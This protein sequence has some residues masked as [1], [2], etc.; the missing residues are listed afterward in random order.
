MSSVSREAAV[1]V[2]PRLGALPN[3]WR[4]LLAE[5]RPVPMVATLTIAYIGVA[6]GGGGFVSAATWLIL[7]AAGTGLFIAHLRDT[8]VDF[9]ERG[10]DRLLPPVG[11][12]GSNGL[13]SLR[14][15]RGLNIGASIVFWATVG[16]LLVLTE[17]VLLLPVAGAAFALAQ[18][19]G[20]GLDRH[21]LSGALTYPTGALLAFWSGYVAAGGAS[22]SLPLGL[23]AGALLAALA[24][25]KIV[26]DLIDEP[27]DPAFGK[28]TVAVAVGARSARRMGIGIVT[29]G[30]LFILVGGSLGG[31]GWIQLATMVVALSIPLGGGWQPPLRATYTVLGGI[32]VAILLLALS[33]PTL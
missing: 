13:L 2:P 30:L 7:L 23:I 16:A 9:Y 3:L 18:S 32:Y 15:L 1:S 17:A 21:P 19:Y 26:S 27:H 29:A 12:D 11:L 20:F 24:G 4:G 5:I 25:G 6:L 14:M 28:R 33:P 8:E 31:W 10:E 22:P